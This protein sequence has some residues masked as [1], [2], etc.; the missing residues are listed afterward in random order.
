V[1]T[2]KV[3]ALLWKESLQVRRSRG[4]VIA[5]T[6]IPVLFLLGPPFLLLLPHANRIGL[7]LAAW[8]LPLGFM[9]VGLVGP[10]SMGMESVLGERDRR[11][12]ELLIALPVSVGEILTAKFIAASVLP[13]AVMLPF[14][15]L[16]GIMELVVLQVPWFYA[17]LLLLISLASLATGVAATLLL[18]LLT[19]DF[20]IANTI[21]GVGAI[22]LFT[23]VQLVMAVIP[24]P[25]PGRI[26]AG[27]G[28]LG[29]VALAMTAI[30]VRWLTFERYLS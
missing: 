1:I 11:T 18:S 3:R 2:T 21:Y 26:A 5:N 27:A 24:L 9:F 13:A 25:M 20:R 14:L 29:L 28:F 30:S 7:F 16:D 10:G 6:V 15:L 23:V 17:A 4:A 12:L 22:G 19:R 8:V